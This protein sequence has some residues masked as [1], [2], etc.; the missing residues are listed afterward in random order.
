MEPY[1]RSFLSYDKGNTMIEKHLEILGLPMKDRVTGMEGMVSSVSF[2]AYGCVQGLLT[3]KIDKDGKKLDSY[4]FD[5]KR[6][7][8][9]GKRIMEI[10]LHFTTPPGLEA[11]PADKPTYDSLPAID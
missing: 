1:I 3:R 4:W 2:D 8:P 11:G 7:E 5:V 6:L 10:P 9:N